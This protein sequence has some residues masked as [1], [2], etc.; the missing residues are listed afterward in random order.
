M[1]VLYTFHG[2]VAIFGR[3]KYFF[4]T[5]ISVFRNNYEISMELFYI[6]VYITMYT[7]IIEFVVSM[8]RVISM[9]I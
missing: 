8:V 1:L 2:Y 5:L 9:Q 4:G 6:H 7:M 3:K